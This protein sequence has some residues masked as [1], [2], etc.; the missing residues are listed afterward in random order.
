MMHVKPLERTAVT[1]RVVPAKNT[2]L[3]LGPL[4]VER[5]DLKPEDLERALALKK[6]RGACLRD[7]LLTHNMVSE[8][9]LF[10]ALKEQWRCEI[11]D[12][13]NVPLTRNS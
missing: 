13:K 1:T 10:L 6:R 2:R 8:N 12:L 7:V 11:P 4:L 3:L 9:N 5:G